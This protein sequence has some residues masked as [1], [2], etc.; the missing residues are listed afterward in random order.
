MKHKSVKKYNFK[1]HD[2]L[3]LDAN[4]WLYLYAPQKPQAY[5]VKIYSEV[6]RRILKAGSKIHTDV[7]VVAEFV[8]RY[9]RSKWQFDESHSDE[10]DEFKDFRNSPHFK[11]VASAIA[12][13]VKRVLKHCSRIESGFAKLKTDDLLTDYSAGNSDFNDLVIAELCKC[14]GLTLITNDGDFKNQEIPVLSANPKL[15]VN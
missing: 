2:K 13:D 7:L 1:R 14:N 12:A 10:F 15:L 8:N 6:F 4:I 5:W 9:A 3:F 11:P